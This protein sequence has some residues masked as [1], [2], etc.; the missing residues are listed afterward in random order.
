MSQDQ[1]ENHMRWVGGWNLPSLKSQYNVKGEP[2]ED[3]QN[4]T[5]LFKRCNIMKNCAR[6]G[7]GTQ[8]NAHQ[9]LAAGS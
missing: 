5:T 1:T 7:N 2:A 8:E 6:R 3:I 4:R 9:T